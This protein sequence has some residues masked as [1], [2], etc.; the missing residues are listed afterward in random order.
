[1]EGIKYSKKV[2]QH[3]L[4]PKHFG[5]IKN[6][7]AVG[8]AGNMKCGDI[9]RVYLEIKN[10]KIIDAKF[11]TFGCAAAIAASDVMC[12]LIIGKTIQQAKKVTN[13]DIVNYLGMLP[14]VKLHCSVLGMQTLQDA[15]KKIKK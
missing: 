13:K 15:I 4:K 8:E 12:E 1:M 7:D 10:G 5:E 6:A 3:F 9:M 14:T 11:K 2:M